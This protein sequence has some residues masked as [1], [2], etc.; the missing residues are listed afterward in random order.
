MGR[1]ALEGRIGS[2]WGGGGVFLL[3][4]Y[5]CERHNSATAVC[6]DEKSN[7]TM[8]HLSSML[9]GFLRYKTETI[10][11]GVVHFTT[12]RIGGNN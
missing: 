7:Y 2:G 6:R 11:E 8:F 4:S 9:T 12:T 3:L 1:V 10:I 5:S